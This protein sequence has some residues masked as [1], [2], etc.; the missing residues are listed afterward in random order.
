VPAW[1]RLAVDP[2]L[3]AGGF[4]GCGKGL[5]LRVPRGPRYRCPERTPGGRQRGGDPGGVRDPPVRVRGPAAPRA[6]R[7]VAGE[8]AG[9]HHHGEHVFVAAADRR[10]GPGSRRSPPGCRPREGCWP[11]TGVKIFGRSWSSR[12]AVWPCCFG[13]FIEVPCLLS[14]LDLPLDDPFRRSSSSWRSTAAFWGR[15]KT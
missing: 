6:A 12:D 1:N 3:V 13:L 15:G 8:V 10:P 5:R 9:A 14:E 7:G 11:R 4:P 2:D